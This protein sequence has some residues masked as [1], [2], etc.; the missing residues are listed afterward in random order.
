MSMR[1]EL[2]AAIDEAGRGQASGSCASK[3]VRYETDLDA[4]IALRR[5]RAVRSARPDGLPEECAFYECTFCQG[6]HLT[7]QPQPVILEPFARDDG[8]TWESYAR[9]LERRVK[10]QRDQLVD[11]QTLRRE[12]GNRQT[13]RQIER[14]ESALGKMT[15]RWEWER[16]RRK[17]L[18]RHLASKRR[19]RSR[20][21]GLLRRSG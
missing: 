5:V 17:G 15:Y 11:L 20:V 2:S 16:D 14:L 9:R 6:W 13:R 18:E 4:A 1:D 21:T 10:E 12:L 3:K 19:L 8:E 7:S